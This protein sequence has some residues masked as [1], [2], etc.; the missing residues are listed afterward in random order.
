MLY[1]ICFIA[2]VITAVVLEVLFVVGFLQRIKN[3]NKEVTI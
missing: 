2:G 1:V 3:S